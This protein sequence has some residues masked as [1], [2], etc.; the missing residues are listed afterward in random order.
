MLHNGDNIETIL[1]SKYQ[2]VNVYALPKLEY[3]DA[4]A[5]RDELINRLNK[6]KGEKHEK[7]ADETNEGTIT[8]DNGTNQ[9]NN[10][11]S[12]GRDDERTIQEIIQR[13]GRRVK[14]RSGNNRTLR[15][16]SNNPNIQMYTH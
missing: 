16:F 9:E 2:N 1:N 10:G 4:L 13:N 12:D 7:R 15:I 3:E 6:A 5:Y 14:G 8:I 11:D